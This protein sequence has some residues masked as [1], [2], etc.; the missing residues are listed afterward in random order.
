M[1]GDFS[2]DTFDPRRH[3]S[4]VLMQ[5]GRVQLDA[6][7]NEQGAILLHAVRTLARDVFGAHAGP[8]DVLGFEIITDATPDA[9]LKIDRFE[10]DPGRRKVLMD[11]LAE[12]DAVI[13][14][15]RYYV[16]G[17][18]VESYRATLYSEQ[19]GYGSPN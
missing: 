9:H 18:L 11:A 14:P 7:W 16:Q 19:P 1:R 4:R 3:Y 10:A 6:D 13:G 2:R 12:G 8:R 5:Q 17:V 15:G